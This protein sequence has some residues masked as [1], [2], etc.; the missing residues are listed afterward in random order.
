V[1]KSGDGDAENILKVGH[2]RAAKWSKVRKK[3]PKIRLQ[4][5]VCEVA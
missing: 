2:E 1:E 3:L 4:K 5:F